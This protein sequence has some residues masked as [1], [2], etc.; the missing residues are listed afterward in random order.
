MNLIV[1]TFNSKAM[2][3]IKTLPAFFI[4]V[5]VFT[6]CLKEESLNLA[7]KGY[8]PV[9]TL[10]G[11]DISTPEVEN[12]NAGILENVYRD[13]YNDEKYPTIR[14]LLVIRN[15][16]LVAEAYCKDV[17]DRDR[18]HNIMS[19][20]KSITSILTG[21]ALDKKMIASIN[22]KVYTY[23]PL[24]FTADNLK[25]EIT[26]QNLLTME[27]GLDFNND[28]H[29]SELINHTGS[30]LEYVLEKTLLFNPGT[31]WS[32]GDG[33]PQ[34]ISGIIQQTSQKSLALFAEEHLFYPLGITDYFWEAH[35]DGLTFG[36]IG[37]WLTPRDMAK[38]GW[39]MAG[40]GF[41][42]GKSVLSEEWVS[43]ST[44]KQSEHQ[45]YGYYWY[46]IEDRAFYAEG[47]G[48][49]IIWV[50]PE[51]Q[52]VVVITSDP[53]AKAYNLSVGYEGLFSEIIH[54]LK[55]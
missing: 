47:H 48:G 18:L 43:I 30:S 53:F 26:I 10:D 28:I 41:W 13:F 24:Y 38:I 42:N 54:S 22:D 25:K 37:L 52:L 29:T 1:W 40:N 32:Y 14:S 11:W 27:S 8:S 34:I 7:Y 51:K 16:K 5:F 46:P 39:L 4:L 19:V 3:T 31:S 55:D 49:Q 9:K 36:S 35:N 23:L 6:S 50:Y 21:I 33:N 44:K 17:H 20:A 2:K 12:M 15:N 45:N